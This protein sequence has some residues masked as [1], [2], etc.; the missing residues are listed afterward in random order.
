MAGDLVGDDAVLAG[1]AGLRADIAELSARLDT[2]DEVADT[3]PHRARQLR[4]VHQLGREL[5]EVH[6][7]WAKEVERELGD[8]PPT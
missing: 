8:S 3:L 2:A 1:L 5:L 4:L 6:D 7:R